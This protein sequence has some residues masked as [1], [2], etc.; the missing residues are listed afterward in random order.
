M[1]NKGDAVQ[2][3]DTK[4][5]WTQIQAPANAYAFIAA[6]YLKQEEGSTAATVAANQTPTPAPD[7]AP[8]TTTAMPDM[9]TMAAP[10]TEAPGTTAAG[11]VPDAAMPT[12]PNMPAMSDTTTTATDQE[13]P[14]R[15]VE[16]EG[17]V[18]GTF[19][20]QAPSKFQLVS[21]DTKQPIDYLY[22]TA[23]NL[24]LGRYKGMHI[25]VTGEE[26]LDPRWKNT[27]VITIQKI[28]V[29]D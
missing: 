4:G 10:P 5:D 19:S 27:P 15:I 14:P 28:E 25:I 9:P 17:V 12:M 1:L 3:V 8:A 29:L 21:L 2:T 24:D 22:T 23:T 6:Q 20:I 26:A 7:T 18:R 11:M 13:P 16:H